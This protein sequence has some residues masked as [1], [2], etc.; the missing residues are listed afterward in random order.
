MIR[1]PAGLLEDGLE[2]AEGLIFAET[3][4]YL[5]F[6]AETQILNLTFFQTVR[7]WLSECHHG[8]CQ[9]SRL[10]FL[11]P[12]GQLWTV[13][14]LWPGLHLR[15]RVRWTRQRA[16]AG[17]LVAL[18]HDPT[19]EIARNGFTPRGSTHDAVRDRRQTD[20]QSDK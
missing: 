2:G 1:M 10:P 6:V 20:A 19:R 18:R 11:L 3:S 16:S 7:Q 9:R 14:G 15:P 17:R 4:G 13:P 12:P 8:G 5:R